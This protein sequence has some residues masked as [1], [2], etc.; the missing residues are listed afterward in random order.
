MINPPGTAETD[1]FQVLLN[2]LNTEIISP[3]LYLFTALA[4]IYFAW[5]LY[6]YIRDAASADGRKIGNQHI[7]YGLIGL[8][9]MALAFT[10]VHLLANTLG[11]T[12]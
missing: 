8:A 10:V 4:V 2:K 12:L 1:S 6:H 3:L 7:M 9:L 5:G 11:V